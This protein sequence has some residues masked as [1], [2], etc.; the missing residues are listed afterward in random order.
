MR[1]AWIF[2]L[3]ASPLAAAPPD[4]GPAFDAAFIEGHNALLAQMAGPGQTPPVLLQGWEPA[5]PASALEAARSGRCVMEFTISTS[6]VPTELH[7]VRE[8][9]PVLCGH[10]AAALFQWRYQ[11]ATDGGEPMAMRMRVPMDFDLDGEPADAPAVAADER[12]GGAGPDM[13]V[14]EIP[15]EDGAV[16]LHVPGVHARTAA[17]SR[18]LMC[19]YAELGRERGVA[20]WM[21]DYP[22][23]DRDVVELR[24]AGDA[25]PDI[26]IAALATFCGLPAPAP[27]DLST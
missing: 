11:P 26:D 22:D 9:D 4:L 18:R 23:P 21:L 14:T 20:G 3:A 19:K 12:P 6:G 15:G 7:M 17:Q 24:P 10:A 2:L 8:D 27:A 5:Y 1:A 16:R 13:H 25:E